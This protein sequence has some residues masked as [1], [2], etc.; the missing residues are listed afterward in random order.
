MVLT[1]H[2]E[3]DIAKSIMIVSIWSRCGDCLASQS[4]NGQLTPKMYPCG[5]LLDLPVLD[6]PNGNQNSRSTSDDD[7]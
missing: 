2:A 6:Q 5:H 3:A 4:G 1:A 7:S